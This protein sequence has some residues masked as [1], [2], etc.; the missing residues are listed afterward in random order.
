MI[1]LRWAALGG[2]RSN[3][4]IIV[5]LPQFWTPRGGRLAPSCPPSTTV[6]DEA[7]AELPSS[8]QDPLAMRVRE[9]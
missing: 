2:L 5:K 1:A 4:V 7:G 6:V 3:S 9:Y 8:R